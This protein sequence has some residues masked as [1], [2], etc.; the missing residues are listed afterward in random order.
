L[1]DFDQRLIDI[2]PEKAPTPLALCCSDNLILRMSACKLIELI[3]IEYN[4]S[5]SGP[6]Y[7]EVFRLYVNEQRGKYNTAVVELMR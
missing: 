6:T 3:D 4:G 7:I 1:N 2:R 5:F